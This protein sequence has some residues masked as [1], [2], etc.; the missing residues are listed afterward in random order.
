M[1]LV[2][3]YTGKSK[4]LKM[5]GGFHGIS[6]YAEISSSPTLET[7]GNFESPASVACSYG[8]PSVVKDEMVIA[9]LNEKEIT[10]S[11]IKSHQ[12]ELAAV[13]TEPMLGTGGLITVQDG[14]LEFLRE[15]TRQQGT[16]FVFDEIITARL[17]PGG[18]Q[19]RFGVTPDLCLLGKIIG[20]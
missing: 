20:A 17:G 9:S 1:R 18:A 4:I 6:D 16:L 19:Q 8:I 2:R 5:E 7:A 10:A 12:K 3:A 11:I 14:Y 15:I 13:F